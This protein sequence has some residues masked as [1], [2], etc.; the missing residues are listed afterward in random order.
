VG[1]HGP[2]HGGGQQQLPAASSARRSAAPG[3]GGDGGGG[4]GGGGGGGDELD[5]RWGGWRTVATKHPDGSDMTMY[6]NVVTG[7]TTY[8]APKPRA[9]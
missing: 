4:D 2:Q 3:G 9:S 7:E 8:D 6:T 5:D 1:K